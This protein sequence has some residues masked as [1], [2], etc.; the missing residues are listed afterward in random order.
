MH[1]ISFVLQLGFELF[2]SLLTA[3]SI[4]VFSLRNGKRE[5]LTKLLKPPIMTLNIFLNPRWSTEKLAKY[6]WSISVGFSPDPSGVSDR[7]KAKTRHLDFEAERGW[8]LFTWARQTFLFISGTAVIHMHV[9]VYGIT[10]S[11]SHIV[12]AGGELAAA[13]LHFPGFR[14]PASSAAPQASLHWVQG[15]QEWIEGKHQHVVFNRV[16]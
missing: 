9:H 16:F 1:S 10:G 14:G 7:R 4:S 6:H 2:H 8:C 15:T 11:S 5:T 12:S 13:S 3:L